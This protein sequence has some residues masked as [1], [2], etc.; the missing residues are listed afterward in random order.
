MK[1]YAQNVGLIK[2]ETEL[3]EVDSKIHDDLKKWMPMSL[4][5]WRNNNPERPDAR[6]AFEDFYKAVM[7]QLTLF[8]GRIEQARKID[9]DIP[10]DKRIPKQTTILF[11]ALTY[12]WGKLDPTMKEY[13]KYFT[14]IERAVE[15]A[16]RQ[17]EPATIPGQ[18]KRS[19]REIEIRDRLEKSGVNASSLVL[20]AAKSGRLEI[21][22]TVTESA[23]PC[24]PKDTM[25][26]FYEIYLNTHHKELLN[27]KK[28]AQFFREALSFKVW[29]LN[30][31]IER[32]SNSNF[33]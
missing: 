33:Q 28:Q 10:H 19:F 3:H 26:G 21:L 1:D 18:L 31:G 30:Y 32:L 20:E 17:P 22:Q 5:E 2:T 7:D 16:K 8:N 15:D 25:D 14:A 24:I 27:A 9:P 13:E 6:V 4:S 29:C 12:F 11:D 23:F